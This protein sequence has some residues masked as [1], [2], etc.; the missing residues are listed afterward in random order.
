M[1][2]AEEKPKDVEDGENTVWIHHQSSGRRWQRGCWGTANIWRDDGW[3]FSSNNEKLQPTNSWSLTSPRQLT[4]RN[5]TQ[6]YHGGTAASQT[7][8]QEQEDMEEWGRL[9]E[10]LLHNLEIGWGLHRPQQ[11]RQLSCRA[12]LFRH[13]EIGLFW[14]T[15]K[16]PLPAGI[17]PWH[18]HWDTQKC[19]FFQRKESRTKISVQNRQWDFF[20]SH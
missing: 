12:R 2:N 17:R 6:S 13:Q 9:A 7:L 5:K 4:V 18:N 14:Q 16:P 3:E 10:G 19:F 11:H 1:A 20:H 15:S 8:S